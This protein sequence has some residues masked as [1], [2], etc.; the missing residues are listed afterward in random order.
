[1][2][3]NPPTIFAAPPNWDML[4]PEVALGYFYDTS[5]ILAHEREQAA[6]WYKKAAH[7]RVASLSGLWLAR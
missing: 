5:T 4:P 3:Y 7:H 2:K 6:H 1:M